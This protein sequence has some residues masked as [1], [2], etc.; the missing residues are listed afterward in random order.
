MAISFHQLHFVAS[1]PLNCRRFPDCHQL[2]HTLRDI[3]KIYIHKEWLTA[4]TGGDI[5]LALGLGVSKSLTVIQRVCNPIL[6]ETTLNVPVAIMADM[7]PLALEHKW[8][9]VQEKKYS[10][11]DLKTGAIKG[12]KWQSSWPFL[13]RFLCSLSRNQWGSSPLKLLYE[14]SV[15]GFLSTLTVSI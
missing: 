14:L 5:K 1:N 2:Q 3:T 12:F 10:R 8:G 9:P 7:L 15:V 4:L 11:T 6:I 13:T